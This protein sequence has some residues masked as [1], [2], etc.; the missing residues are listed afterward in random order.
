[1][2]ALRA[3]Q[4]TG[5]AVPHRMRFHPGHI[6]LRPDRAR[7]RSLFI[8]AAGFLA[9]RAIIRMSLEAVEYRASDR[10]LRSIWTTIRGVAGQRHLRIHS[11]VRTGA[12]TL[13]PPIVLVHGFGI[14]SSYFVPLAAR[15]SRH[16]AVYVP[17]LPGHGRSGHD[18]RPL[19]IPELAE[20]LAAWT[21]AM[22]LTSVVLVG[23]SLGCQILAEVAWRH[24][25][26][27]A[28]VVLIGPTSDPSG[29][30]VL[31]QLV[32][33]AASWLFERSTLAICMLV[34]YTRAGVSVLRMERASMMSHPMEEILPRVSAPALVVRGGRDAVAPQRW[35]ETVSRLLGAPAPSVIAGWGHAVHY[36]APDA[37]AEVVLRLARRVQR[38]AGR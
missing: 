7:L 30:T 18:A 15:L 24:P 36:D 19:D 27:V 32:R 4:G 3:P 26:R 22:R 8:G 37:V 34:D 6:A 33:L 10:Q 28:G 2:P 29:E 16:A 11:R 9:G 35:A 5:L 25:D 14:A 23:H 20:A 12:H 38:E 21:D 31:R 13:C 1:M 17:E